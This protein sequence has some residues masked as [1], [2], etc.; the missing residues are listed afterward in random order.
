VPEARGKARSAPQLVATGLG[1]RVE[2]W[3]NEVRI[4]KGGFFGHLVEILWIGDGRQESTL[5]LDRITVVQIVRHMFLPDVIGFSYPGSPAFTGDYIHDALAENA[6]IMNLF[7]NRP[8]FA[9]K[10]AI[11]DFIIGRRVRP[12]LAVPSVRQRRASLR[13]HSR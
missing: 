3:D 6:L 1:G 2:L 13:G 10:E 11:E 12:A 5:F 4:I 8:F 7:D 9:I